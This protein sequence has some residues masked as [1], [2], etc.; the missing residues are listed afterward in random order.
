MAS[1]SPP[2]PRE[3]DGEDP[4]VDPRLL[5]AHLETCAS[6]RGY[7]DQVAG[8]RRAAVVAPADEMPDLSRDVTKLNAMAD[9]ASRWWVVR[10]LL[11]LVAVVI[12]VV[13]GARPLGRRAR[14]CTS[15]ATSAPSASPTPWP[16]SWWSCRPAR[17][18]AIFPVTLVL[19]GALFI[20][21][22]IDVV[23]GHVPL[24]NET[25]HLPELLSVAL[26]WLLARPLP[27]PTGVPRPAGPTARRP[28]SCS[29][30]TSP[31]SPAPSDATSVDLVGNPERLIGRPGTRDTDPPLQGPGSRS[32]DAG[33]RSPPRAGRPPRLPV[34]IGVVVVLPEPDAGPARLPI[35][36]AATSPAGVGDMSSVYVVVDNGGG[37][38]T[39]VA[40]TSEAASVVTLHD[41]EE[42]D[43]G[44]Y[45]VDVEGLDVPSGGA[46]VLS[47]GGRHLMLHHVFTPLVP[48]DVVV[49]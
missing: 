7:R 9:R 47:P 29:R 3:A 10:G 44:A 39:V 25:A 46:L 49:F 5:A 30:P 36:A 48:G 45:M 34:V 15:A 11:G 43:G 19:A 28:C 1:G 33:R 24:V 17:A 16:C 32:V 26:V 4:G 8:L 13:V 40:A 37:A 18:R 12:I 2:S 23:E 42:A 35:A 22:V 21:A 6:C 31:T 41:T 27:D 14:R 20:T 38:D